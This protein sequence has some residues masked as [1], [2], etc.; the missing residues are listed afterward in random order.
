MCR[1]ENEDE[2]G[3]SNYECRVTFAGINAGGDKDVTLVWA[4]GNNGSG[5]WPDWAFEQARLA[6]L[7]GKKSSLA[8]RANHAVIPDLA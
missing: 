3:A 7:H 4:T 2:I 5:Y 1:D 6:L 8:L